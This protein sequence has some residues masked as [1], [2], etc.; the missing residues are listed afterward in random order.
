MIDYNNSDFSASS[1]YHSKYYPLNSISET[2]FLIEAKLLENSADNTDIP[3]SSVKGVMFA[4]GVIITLIVGTTWN[5][6]SSLKTTSI[7]SQATEQTE[8]L[9]TL[10]SVKTIK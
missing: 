9:E 6:Y 7:N 4:L 1:R 3:A 8:L 10:S 5:L 2:Q